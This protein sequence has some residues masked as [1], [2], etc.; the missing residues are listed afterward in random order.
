MLASGCT[1]LTE[2]QIREV[3]V[4]AKAV[5]SYDHLPGTALRSYGD[6]VGG[7]R[8]LGLTGRSV[9]GKNAVWNR[10]LTEKTTV[11]AIKAQAT[12]ADVSVKA[13]TTYGT[14]LATLS[15]DSFSEEL[16]KEAK[17]LGDQ[18]D[19]GITAFNK[20][21]KSDL[22]L[23]GKAVAGAI[24]GAG[25]I[26]IRARQAEYVKAAVSHGTPVVNEMTLAI[27]NVVD[28]LAKPPLPKGTSSIL[29]LDDEDCPAEEAQLCG[30]LQDLR[31]AF[32]RSIGQAGRPT[33]PVVRFGSDLLLEVE[34][35]HVAAQASAKGARDVRKAHA[36]LVEALA[37][38]QNLKERIEE[39]KML[40]ADVKRAKDLL[41][42]LTD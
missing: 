37:K 34:R 18:V 41:D 26:Y 39:I 36:K 21:T 5:E 42:K 32:N 27:E 33:L 11:A 13:L 28:P 35:T 6:I 23:V 3:G 25:R 2:S 15:S 24:T 31:D 17:N 22:G 29:G 38:K 8:L 30:E 1:S 9:R 4:Y 14:L 12:A 10:L 16:E 19:E 40:V 7:R 20:L